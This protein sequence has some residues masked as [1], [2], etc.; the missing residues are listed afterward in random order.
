MIDA[1]APVAR[2]LELLSLASKAQD[3]V[4]L[5]KQALGALSPLGPLPWHEPERLALCYDSTGNVVHVSALRSFKDSPRYWAIADFRIGGRGW[6]SLQ[7]LRKLNEQTF[8]LRAALLRAAGDRPELRELHLRH[9]TLA[10]SAIGNW[11]LAHALHAGHAQKAYKA[12]IG[13]LE[14]ALAVA[15]GSTPGLELRAQL[16]GARVGE[17]IFPTVVFPDAVRSK[18]AQVDALIAGI[19]ADMRA[20]QT[21]NVAGAAKLGERWQTFRAAWVAHRD[22]NSNDPWGPG[23]VL[24]TI[25]IL[26]QTEAFERD[27]LVYRAELAKLG[28][29]PA[30]PVPAP[31]PKQPIDQIPEI[32]DKAA[33]TIKVVAI[34]AAVI[35][36][37][38]LVMESR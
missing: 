20:A 29:E 33:S 16:A 11:T 37:V 32:A 2:A 30:T 13:D 10:K 22:A 26:Q 28:G 6:T 5:V 8:A 31:P 14:D 34:S 3:R 27:A 9:A 15:K 36:G 38:V 25:A 21:R 17:G 1:R 4:P 18:I 24:G 23:Q 7:D 12:L 19:D 35:A